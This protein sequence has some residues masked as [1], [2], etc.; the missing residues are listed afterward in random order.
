MSANDPKQTLGRQ[1]VAPESLRIQSR[2]KANPEAADRTGQGVAEA[3]KS[4]S[5]TNDLQGFLCPN[6]ALALRQI[7]VP[8]IATKPPIHCS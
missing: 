7:Y 1:S 6:V 8:I 2:H 5:L 3:L 4:L